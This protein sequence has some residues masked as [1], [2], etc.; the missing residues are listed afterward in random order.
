[1]ITW[2]KTYIN[3]IILGIL[4]SIIAYLAVTIFILNARIVQKDDDIQKLISAK[5]TIESKLKQA[6]D[7]AEIKIFEATN[8]CAYRNTLDDIES[9]SSDVEL[10]PEGNYVI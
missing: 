8:N 7:E 9:I 4:A 5:T 1:M 3:K 6:Q 10:I 2:I